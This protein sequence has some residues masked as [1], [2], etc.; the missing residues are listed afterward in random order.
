MI[1]QVIKISPNT[2]LNKKLP[3]KTRLAYSLSG[4]PEWLKQ[5]FHQAA[6]YGWLPSVI[7][8]TVTIFVGFP[9]E[10]IKNYME[11]WFN[12][13]LVEIVIDNPKNS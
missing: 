4:N 12:P 3:F 11:E 7:G 8:D 1:K 6:S 2:E 9:M 10:E 13:D 5:A